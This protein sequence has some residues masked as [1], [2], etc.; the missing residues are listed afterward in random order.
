M[1]G[2]KWPQRA[3]VIKRHLTS[4][5]SVRPENVL[6]YSAGYE[7]QKVCGVFSKT[8]A[9][10]RLSAPSLGWLYIRSAIFPTDNMHAHCACALCIRKV[11]DRHSMPCKLSLRSV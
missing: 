6:T 4:G 10:L 8:H 7:G 1:N 5:A 2:T 9:F 11:R 3:T